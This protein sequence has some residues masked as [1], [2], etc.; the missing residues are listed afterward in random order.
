MHVSGDGPATGGRV[1]PVVHGPHGLGAERSHA[2]ARFVRT[3]TGRAAVLLAGGA[4][5]LV[6]A[7]V[8]GVLPRSGARSCGSGSDAGR[9]AR[10]AA[11]GQQRPDDV[12]LL[13]RRARGAPRVRPRRAARAAPVRPAAARALGGMAVPVAIYLGFNAGEPTAHGWGVAMSTDTAFALGL[14]A[15]VGPRFPARLRA[16]MLTIAVVDDIVALIVIAVFYTE[17]HRASG[18]CS[19][20]IAIFSAL[21]VARAARCPQRDPVPRG[22]HRGVGR[23]LEVGRR[24]DRGRP[25]L[26][27]DHVRLPVVARRARARDRAVPRLPRAADAR[28]G[29]RRAAGPRSTIS[30]N[31]R[32]QQVFHPWTSYLIVPIFALANAGVVDRRRSIR[33]RASRRR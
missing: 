29:P 13:R 4:R 17:R 32:L 26:R 9:R 19:S 11:V 23:G 15:L 20:R 18:R 14:L 25:R 31:E 28:A 10:P 22:R 1:E 24:S 3:E 21:L 30:P 5:A 33:A 7:N 6:W 8:D 2:T 12:L 27:A 16:F